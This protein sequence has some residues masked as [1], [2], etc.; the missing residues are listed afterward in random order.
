MR[1]LLDECL[2]KR[3]KRDLVGHQARTVPEMG[4]ASK[5]NG[6]LLA[7]AEVEFDAFLTVDRNLS[8]QQEINRL[9]IAVV[10]L[11]AKGNR[12]SDLQP[13]V[14]DLLDVLVGVSPGQLIRVGA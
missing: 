1:I 11:V 10:V 14:P 4:W 8:F 13:L 6:E 5:K 12:H 7:L 9:D 2:P 3:L